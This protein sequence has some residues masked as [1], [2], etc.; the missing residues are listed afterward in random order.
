MSIVTTSLLGSIVCSSTQS[1]YLR[2]LCALCASSFGIHLVCSTNGK[3]SSV[4]CFLAFTLAG[5]LWLSG[6]MISYRPLVTSPT[7]HSLSSFLRLKCLQSYLRHFWWFVWS[8]SWLCSARVSFTLWE[9]T[10]WMREQD[11]GS[12]AKLS[13]AWAKLPL[14]RS[15]LK[16]KKPALSV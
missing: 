6:T 1:W 7:L 5:W 15:T 8:L 2:R 14:E 3:W 12:N 9:S 11:R 4:L 16:V 10:F 13:T